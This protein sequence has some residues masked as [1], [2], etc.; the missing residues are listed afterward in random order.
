MISS[1]V[2]VEPPKTSW[3]RRL[4]PGLLVAATGVGAGDLVAASVAGSKYGY[5]LL[6]ACLVGAVLK[7]VLNE[8]IARWQLATG[9]TM[10]EGWSLHLGRWAQNY[11][12]LYT[13][14]WGFVVGAA[15][16]SAC[17]LAAHAIS[18]ILSIP[19][20]G[21]LHSLA[22]VVVVFVGQYKGFERTMEILVGVMFFSLLTCAFW[23]S[24]P[25]K[26]FSLAFVAA[27]LPRSSGAF[28]MSVI[29]GVGGSLTLLSYGYWMR[30]AR[31]Q[32]LSWLKVARLDLAIAYGL[33]G[34]FGIAVMVIA[35]ALLHPKGLSIQGSKGLLVLASHLREAIGLGGGWIFLLGFWAAVTTSMLGV[36]QSFPYLVCDLLALRRQASPSERA[37]LLSTQSLPFRLTLLGLAFPPALLLFAQKPVALI[38]LYA[39]IG[40]LFMP[41]LALTLLLMNNRTS[42]VGPHARNGILT[43]AFLVLA[44]ALFLV[45]GGRE[46]YDA[47]LPFFSS[48]TP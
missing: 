38:V 30:E 27:D 22:A 42:L 34:L 6:W 46:I 2:E 45:L 19:A 20:W 35:A 40:S 24:P 13:A 32:G 47:L 33:T 12:L 16:I 14:I 9:L 5:A 18:P 1:G 39:V 43:N 15:L 3:L 4:G 29:G 31:W 36:W 25:T 23:L 7:F 21:L 8:G 41:W 44:L 10:L 37:A 17:G 26:T 11:I 48:K 28:V